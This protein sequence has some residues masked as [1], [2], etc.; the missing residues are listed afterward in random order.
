LW[1]YTVFAQV[2]V[3][4]KQKIWLEYKLVL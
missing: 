3:E 1:K 2:E 4:V